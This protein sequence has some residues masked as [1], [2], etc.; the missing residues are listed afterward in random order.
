MNMKKL[1]LALLGFGN[2]GQA[3]AALLLDKHTE[4]IE[5][6]GVDV[7]VSAIATVSKGSL[8]DSSGIDLAKALMDVELTGKFSVETPGHCGFDAQQTLEQSDYDVAVEMTP[9]DIHSGQPAL[10]YIE[11][12]LSRGKH[13]ISA[14]KGPLAYGARKLRALALKNGVSYLYETTVMD[15]TPVFNLAEETLPM[16]RVMEIQGILNTTTNFILDEMAAGSTYEIALEEG[17]RRGFVEADPSM[18]ID[19]WDA[20]AK[21]TAL[22]NVLM[23]TDIRPVDIIRNGIANVTMAD[24]ED[25]AAQNKVIKLFCRGRFEAGVPVGSVDLV[26]LNLSHPYASVKGTSSAVTLYTDLMG[27]LTVIEHNP[28]IEQ[29]GYGIFSDLVRLIR[30][31]G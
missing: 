3:F 23:G 29:T 27:P 15:G 10:N 8:I 18:D 16:C 5:L 6:Y 25:A 14:N 26:S 22:M 12:A 20:A 19:G 11:T 4:I 17:Q 31:L 2:A 7:L 30:K 24:I 1:K 13:V 21:L 28:E 9:L